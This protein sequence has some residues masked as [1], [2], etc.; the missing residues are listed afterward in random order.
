MLQHELIE[1]TYETAL[2]E[3]RWP[4]LLRAIADLVGGTTAFLS[5]RH[6]L[7]ARIVHHSDAGTRDT[8]RDYDRY[9]ARR[10]PCIPGVNRLRREFVTNSRTVAPN[11]ENT[12]FYNEY[13][14]PA[15]RRDHLII[16]T[17]KSGDHRQQILVARCEDDACF[18]DHDAARVRF[19]V[20]R[21]L[22]AGQPA[23]P[24]P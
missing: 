12:A 20:P 7:D 3:Q 21:L 18:G 4:E 16:N 9:W 23:S 24:M 17:F 15:G 10:D 22:K 6:G 19:L 8:T 2:N 13:C 5:D 14:K 11:F 1:L